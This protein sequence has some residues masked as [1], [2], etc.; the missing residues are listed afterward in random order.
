MSDKPSAISKSSGTSSVQSAVAKAQENLGLARNV[1]LQIFIMMESKGQPYPGLINDRSITMQR[2]DF[3]DKKTAETLRQ[4]WLKNTQDGRGQPPEPLE[5]RLE[6]Q[7]ASLEDSFAA[8]AQRQADL[9]GEVPND[10]LAEFIAKSKLPI[11]PEYRIDLPLGD[12]DLRLEIIDN[13]VPFEN[14]RAMLL[15][16][17]REFDLPIRSI[18]ITNTPL[19]GDEHMQRLFSEPSPSGMM[20]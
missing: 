8:W 16:F 20:N 14:T 4:L 12:D 11:P 15:K 2:T 5:S 1:S 3:V 9:E 7:N 13:L 19:T 17:E 10:L 6:R 18:D